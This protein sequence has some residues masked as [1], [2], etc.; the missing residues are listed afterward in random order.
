MSKEISD[1]LKLDVQKFLTNGGS[2]EVLPPS[3]F[4]SSE[5]LYSENIV[6]KDTGLTDKDIK[7]FKY[8]V[9]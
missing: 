7:E 2:I 8:K 5:Y 1:K 9:W 4:N 6:D 3:K